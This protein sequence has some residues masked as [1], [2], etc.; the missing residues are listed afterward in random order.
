MQRSSLVILL[1]AA[2][3]AMQIVQLA[4]ALRT[5]R[6]RTRLG[7]VTRKGQPRRF[8]RYV[9]T[10]YVVVLLCAAAIVW[11]LISPGSF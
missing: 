10:G 6:M 9:Y 1:A 7:T 5:G 11:A 4:I 3:A 8:W 2:L